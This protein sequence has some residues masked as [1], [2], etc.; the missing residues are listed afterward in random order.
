MWLSYCFIFRIF[1]RFPNN[2]AK[3]AVNFSSCVGSVSSLSLLSNSC[4]FVSRVDSS[5]LS[6]MGR[7]ASVVVS[8]SLT[9]ITRFWHLAHHN[10]PVL[11]LKSGE[12]HAGHEC[13]VSVAPCF[14]RFAMVSRSSE[15]FFVTFYASIK[16]PISLGCVFEYS[17]C[18]MDFGGLRLWLERRNL[19]NTKKE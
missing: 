3:V 14:S 18:G 9:M 5:V 16:K 7:V 15:S 19:R 1:S 11:S 2:A 13:S 4:I 8:P 17:L 10:S 6:T 12:A